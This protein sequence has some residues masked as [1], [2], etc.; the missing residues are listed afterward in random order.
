MYR[1]DNATSLPAMPTPGPI[2]PNPDS[3]FT[4][5]DPTTALNATIVDDDWLNSIQEEICNVIE[6]TGGTLTKGVYTQ[7]Y[8]AIQTLLQNV[9]YTTSST[10]ANTYTASFSPAF[11]DYDTGKVFVIKFTHGNTGAATLNINGLGAKN[12]KRLDGNALI[13][14][15]IYDG[16]IALM[17]YDGTNIQVLNLNQQHLPYAA[18]TTASNTYTATLNPIA[19][20][21]TTG[22]SFLI[23][24]TNANTGA[25]TLNVKGLG[26]KDIKRPDG[27]A[28]QAGDIKAGMVA[29]FSYDGTNL[30]LLNVT[31]SP[32]NITDIFTSSDTF[33]APTGVYKVFVK[34]WGAGGSGGGSK[35]ATTSASGS[36]GG[37][38]AYVEGWVDVV[39]GVGYAITIGS[40]GAGVAANTNDDG[41][42]GAD[43]SFASD[44]I[45]KAGK[46]GKHWVNG[47]GA[48]GGQGGDKAACTGDFA[49]SGQD[50]WTC[51]IATN[52]IFITGFGGASP[53]NTPPRMGASL[54]GSLYDGQSNSGQGGE[55]GS[56]S[57]GSGDGGSGLLTVSY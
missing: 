1:I 34:A 42:D 21:Y 27:S 19:L 22:M 37:G 36:G 45:A 17:A 12:L 2:G 40:G 31:S 56:F 10:V 44:I 52:R 48:Q 32:R 11:S 46:G 16:M 38:G 55:G 39:P 6:L 29:H 20:G 23:K 53:N 15:D 30:Q 35:E 43:T 26:A 25:A 14:N 5:G 13:A 41:N 49:L 33:T 47:A 9:P 28:L 57:L 51:N 50:G 54:S 18:S 7:L 24:F 4:K 8:D 3:F